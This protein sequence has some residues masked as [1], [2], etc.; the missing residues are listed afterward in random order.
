[1]VAAG[2]A[3]VHVFNRMGIFSLKITI[4]PHLED[5]AP[6]SALSEP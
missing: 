6:A 2:C 4:S 5:F 1:M 3:F